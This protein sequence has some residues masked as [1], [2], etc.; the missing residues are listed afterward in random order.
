MQ[1]IKTALF[2]KT[3]TMRSTNQKYRPYFT[4]IELSELISALK[5][6][7][8]PSRIALIRYLE[9]FALKI[10]HGIISSAHTLEPSMSEKLELDQTRQEII[11]SIGSKRFNAYRKWRD[12]PNKCTPGE[13]EMSQMYK[14]ENDLMTPEE[15]LELEKSLRI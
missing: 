8:K 14:Y 11:D 6:T 12:F 9:G 7:P 10:S 1:V 2:L 3:P 4:S 15:E 13:I 5:E